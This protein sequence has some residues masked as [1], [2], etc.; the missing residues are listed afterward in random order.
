MVDTTHHQYN[1]ETLPG[2]NIQNLLN[3]RKLVS[4]VSGHELLTK[5]HEICSKIVSNVVDKA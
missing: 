3:S 5:L 1:V 2:V 4:S